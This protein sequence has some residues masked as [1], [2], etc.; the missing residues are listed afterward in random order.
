MSLAPTA[1]IL[2][3]EQGTEG[4]DDDWD[5]DFEDSGSMLPLTSR[6]ALSGSAEDNLATI[7][8]RSSLL[9]SLNA[10]SGSTSRPVVI[11]PS[12][13]GPNGPLVEDYS[14]LVADGD[15]DPFEGRVTSLRV[16][17]PWFVV[18]KLN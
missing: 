5:K 2:P 6:R 16:S 18:Y 14:D 11:Q 15:T 1:E 7:K 10:S 8:P 3:P 13:I 9:R 4:G 12:R 17:G